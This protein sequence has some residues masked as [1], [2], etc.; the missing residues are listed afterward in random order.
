MQAAWLGLAPPGPGKLAGSPSS[1]FPLSG[2]WFHFL[3]LSQC[4]SPFS[5]PC[6]LLSLGCWRGRPEWWL[7]L[8]APGP[9]RGTPLCLWV[10][11]SWMGPAWV[12]APTPSPPLIGGR[13]RGLWG[14]GWEPVLGTAG[15]V[16]AAVM[17]WGVCWGRMG[18][19]W[20]RCP[21]QPT[22]GLPSPPPP[23]PRLRG[24]GCALLSAP[25]NWRGRVAIAGRG[26]TLSHHSFL[27]AA[28]PGAQKQ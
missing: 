1:D 4:L 3:I 8:E 2:L 5:S 27:W 26:P 9:P 23:R 25:G 12:R 14:W 21:W 10:P 13:P 17:T 11:E 7:Q 24:R 22:A 20:P 16:S 19:W 15:T 28:L 18:E 6:R